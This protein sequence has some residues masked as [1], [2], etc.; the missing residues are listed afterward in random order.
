MEWVDR[1]TTA[2]RAAVFV[3]IGVLTLRPSSVALVFLAWGLLDPTLA[4]AQGPCQDPS[5]RILSIDR[6]VGYR[7]ANTAVYVP[8]SVSAEIC[9]GDTIRT[10]DR[11]RAT[12]VFVD[13]TRLVIDQNTEWVVRAPAQPNR[14]LI[15]LIRGAIL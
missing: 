14:T 3:R 1:G 12:I 6:Q 2:S 13:N 7:P 5:A 9:Q 8:A 11:S 10:G 15:Q 4:N